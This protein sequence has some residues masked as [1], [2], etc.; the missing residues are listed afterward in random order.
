VRVVEE[1]VT[2]H[3]GERGIVEM[4]VPL[5]DGQLA[6]DDAGAGAG[7]PRPISTAGLRRCASPI[8]P[9]M[10]A[11]PAFRPACTERR[12]KVPALEAVGTEPRWAAVRTASRRYL[13][14]P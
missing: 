8:T 9:T 14:I 5:G 1:P 7:A 11:G 3:V 10:W 2:D 4:G 13:G 12:S 6:G